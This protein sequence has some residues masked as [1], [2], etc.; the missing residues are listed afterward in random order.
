MITFK[1]TRKILLAFAN[2]PRPDPHDWVTGL[3][4]QD[5]DIFYALASGRRV[6]DAFVDDFRDC[7]PNFS[8][9]AKLYAIPRYLSYAIRHP[10]S[11]AT[12]HLVSELERLVHNLEFRN[13]LGF[14]KAKA[15]AFGLNLLMPYFHEYGGPHEF[16]KLAHIIEQFQGIES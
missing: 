4:W 1:D 11:E 7:L 16:T 3:S 2:V 14:D 5:D 10:D 6:N 12:G 15:I 9:D 13:V 8:I